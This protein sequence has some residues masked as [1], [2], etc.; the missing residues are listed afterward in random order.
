MFSS[1]SWSTYFTYAGIA[2]ALYYA[3]IG[4]VFYRQQL[5]SLLS[6]K[7]KITLPN[8]GRPPVRDANAAQ[9]TAQV[10]EVHDHQVLPD[11]DQLEKIIHELR[12]EVIPKAGAQPTKAKLAVVFQN[13][14]STID[15]NLPVLFKNN[16]NQL[17]TREAAEQCG[18]H[19][20]AEEIQQLW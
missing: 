6:A 11:I 5:Q 2:T 7:P 13:Y 19:F 9:K 3:I 14:L 16:I 17:M 10:N 12:H 15:G 18:V 8:T 1:I 4:L 20:S